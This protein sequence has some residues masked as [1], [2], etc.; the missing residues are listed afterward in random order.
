[1]PSQTWPST[2]TAR[3]T[4][5]NKP[6]TWDQVSVALTRLKYELS[7]QPPRERQIDLVALRAR[8]RQAR[9]VR[10]YGWLSK[11]TG[12]RVSD[13]CCDC[14]RGDHHRLIVTDNGTSAEMCPLLFL[15][16]ISRI[17]CLEGRQLG[18]DPQ[19]IIDECKI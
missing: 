12:F 10:K 19:K 3:V 11:I 8:E 6:A 16:R 17:Y 5:G 1:M 2:S 9:F 14:G 15:I 7:Q 4:G 13:E 18:I